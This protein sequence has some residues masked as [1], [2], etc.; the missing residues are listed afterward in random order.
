MGAT[1][2]AWLQEQPITS[3]EDWRNRGASAL[4]WSYPL[5]SLHRS[6]PSGILLD[7]R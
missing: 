1:L 4:L 7:L 6:G 2:T 3:I 5:W